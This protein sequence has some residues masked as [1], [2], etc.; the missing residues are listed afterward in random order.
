MKTPPKRKRKATPTR[1]KATKPVTRKRKVAVRPS[2]APSGRPVRR[3]HAPAPASPTV[4][5]AR[6]TS[7]GRGSTSTRK[8]APVAPPKRKAPARAPA[9]KP[10]APWNKRPPLPRAKRL[11]QTPQA[12]AQRA[13]RAADLLAAQVRA[14][15][16]EKRRTAPRKPAEKLSKT[17]AAIA[18]RKRRAAEVAATERKNALAR[19]RRA[20]KKWIAKQLEIEKQQ[21]LEARRA[22]RVAKKTRAPIDE[23]QLAIGWLE[24]IRNLV[25]G[26]FPASLEIT[27]AEAG[28]GT[29]WLVVGRMDL[30]E[31]VSYE[32]FAEILG[33]LQDDILLEAQI[34]PQRLSQIR[35][36][37]HDPNSK[38][39]EG[40]SIV[41]KSGAWEF[42]LGDLI[43]EIVG[44]GLDDEGSLA[45]RYE[46]TTI[47]TFY[48]YFATEV[49]RYAT[50]P[51]EKLQ[52]IQLKR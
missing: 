23:R 42:V 41:S 12:K 34:N 26:V 7:G 15:L 37:Y 10:P 19:R 43:G 27:S 30:L 45:V 47:G 52:T 38:R 28:A 48:I 33:R 4:R 49:T 13:R 5:M 44:G 46:A 9:R 20:E 8:V 22:G 1:A 2:P 29:P 51:W 35:V 17:P 6:K 24:E 40:D 18:A 50:M 36:I 39:G 11:S 32:D 21:K 25:A 31:V 3:A 16:A 14:K